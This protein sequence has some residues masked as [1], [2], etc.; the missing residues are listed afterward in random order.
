M[1]QVSSIPGMTSRTELTLNVRPGLLTSRESEVAALIARGLSSRQIAEV[2]VVSAR[3]VDTH[4][5]HIRAKLGLHSRIQIAAWA[6]RLGH[7][8]GDN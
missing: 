5:D 7:P 8:F 4:A 2:L 1:R 3:T 6:A